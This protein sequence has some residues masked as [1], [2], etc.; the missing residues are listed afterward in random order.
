MILIVA[1]NAVCAFVLWSLWNAR[2]GAAAGPAAQAPAPPGPAAVFAPTPHV[3]DRALEGQIDARI[4]AAISRAQT[5]T[6]GKL[7]PRE[8]TVAVHVRE[9]GVPG[10][11]V[12]RAADRSL[13][14]ASN[15]KL[16]TTAAALAVLGP[17]WCFETRFETI[18]PLV[19]GHL[20]GD[21]VVRAGGDPLYDPKGPAANGDV[22]HLLAPV[23]DELLRAGVRS[24]DGALVIDEGNFQDPERGPAWPHERDAWKEYCALAGGFSANAGCLTALVHA[25]EGGAAR[26]DVRPDGHGR[27]ER[28][29]VR[30]VG[31]R[32]ALD[33]RVG[34]L[35]DPI[36]V[37]GSIPSDVPEWSARFA[38]PD[39]VELFSSCL[40]AALRERGI[41]VASMART[42]KPLVLG[43]GQRTLALLRTPMAT[44]LEPI[45]TD[46]N[47]ACADQLFLALGHAAGGRG[48]RTGGRAAVAAALEQ[49]GV[50]GASL[51]QVDGSGLSREDRVSARQVT[52]LLDAVLRRD[53][54]SARL[55][56]DSLADGGE[57]GTLDER[58]KDPLL[59]GRVHA[60]TGFI[61][62]TSALSGVLDALDGRTLLFSILVEYPNH[63]GL[64]QSC[65]KPMQDQICGLLARS[66]VASRHDG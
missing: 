52:A 10:E 39:P 13:R 17:D 5:E 60:K 61:N 56:L 30:T 46:S 51:V 8:V 48:T 40:L 23:V 53:A 29:S 63:G 37:E 64:N 21:L 1:A 66:T 26:V 19:D 45:N 43:P 31:A 2:Q 27:P 57:N 65:W 50:E 9:L 33:I 6:K 36:V 22:S 16:V 11:L 62:G 59:A 24:I 3:R 41:A 49:L 7:D 32:Q 38:V 14:P 47:N 4:Q 34:A 42:R 25:T 20:Q 55:F 54:R 18:A 15:L 12:A 44:I 35:R 58:M 28:L